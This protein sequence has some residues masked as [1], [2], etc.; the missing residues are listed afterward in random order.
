M[1]KFSRQVV[2]FVF[3]FLPC[4]IYLLYAFFNSGTLFYSDDFHLLKTV[5]WLKD[6]DS[7]SDK[8]A[9]LIQQHN[10]HRIIIPR[11]ITL[12]D[13]WL[14]GYINWRTLILIGNLLWVS[15][16]VFFWRA[17]KD[18]EQPAWMF[19]P[20]SWI[21]FQPQYFDN[22]TWAISILQQSVIV[23]W[24]ALLSFLLASRR[25]LWALPVVV[26]ATFTHGNGIFGFLIG[27]F[28]L[29]WER[30]WKEVIRWV[31]LFGIV[32]ALYF[33]GFQNGQNSDLGNS[34]SDPVRLITSFFAFFGSIAKLIFINSAYSVFTGIVL[35]LIIAIYLAPKIGFHTETLI[36]MSFF[37]RLLLANFLFLGITGA[38]VSV[39]RS[40]SGV[41]HV[42]APRYQHYS[43]FVLCWAYLILLRYTRGKSRKILAGLFVAGGIVF[44]GLC[45]YVYDGD[46]VFRKEWLVADG[47]NWNNHHVFLMHAKSFNQNIAEP[48]TQAE[49][50]GICKK[51]ESPLDKTWDASISD[52]TFVLTVSKGVIE[53]RDAS[54]VFRRENIRIENNTLEGCTFIYLQSGTEMG[55][56]LP[57]RQSRT[58]FRNLILQR[59]TKAPGFSVD[60]VTENLPTGDYRIGV[61]HNNRFRWTKTFV[62]IDRRP[63]AMAQ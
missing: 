42:L 11:L 45:Y 60:F 46:I 58:S 50:M 12:L 44:N 26:I 9:L 22:V 21:L 41:D 48:Y 28:F 23:F 20:V 6:A 31:T 29:S 19:I 61:L 34:L 37:D 8:F 39:S 5:L 36:R 3:I 17:F 57:G 33:W 16:I 54:G 14:E 43:P 30:N 24:F 62:A 4:V 55:Y 1:V 53:D 32:A 40:W 38:L 52:T 47:T 27:I 13:Y 35:I 7:F 59:K 56:W 2:L 25:Y 15:V 49:L 63:I 10:E 51:T 18:S